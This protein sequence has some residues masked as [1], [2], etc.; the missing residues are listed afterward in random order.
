MWQLIFVLLTIFLYVCLRSGLHRDLV[1][2]TDACR[3]LRDERDKLS[4]ENTNLKEEN[5]SLQKKVE[6]ITAL[7]DITRQICRSLEADKVFDYFK[8]ELSKHIAISDCRFLKD[9]SDL[10]AYN[11]YTV[12]PLEIPGSLTGYLA[13]GGIKEEDKT[14]F[15][16]LSQQFILGIKRARLYQKVQELAITDSLTQAFSRRYYLERFEE[17]IERSKKFHYVFSCL[18]LDIDHFK[19]YNDRYG[20]LA[21]DA[22][23]KE[24]SRVIKESIRHIDLM[25]RYGGEEFSIILTETGEKEARLAAERIRQ[26]IESRHIRVYDEDL[27]ITVSIGVSEFPRD[28]KTI[29]QLID[30]ADSALYKAK[31]TGRNRVCVYSLQLR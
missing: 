15:Q 10:P 24:L 18:M 8:E 26:A 1:K 28:G 30:N 19:D 14:T 31:Q 25:G 29:N 21:G 3:N 11:G 2:K 5:F 4:A 12:V 17:E 22:I 7:Y 27:K 20:H 9:A 6:R 23:L 13:A 16:I